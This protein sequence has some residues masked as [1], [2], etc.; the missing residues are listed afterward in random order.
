MPK[1]LSIQKKIT[2][3]FSTL[4]ILLFATAVISYSILERVEDKM[5]RV[6]V[7]DDFLNLTLE[8]RRYEKNY[9]LYKL[10]E[11]FKDNRAYLDRLDK[12]IIANTEIFS[13]YDPTEQFDK[14]EAISHTYRKSMKRLHELNLTAFND[15]QRK[16]Q[17]ILQEAIRN[18]GKK[19]TYYA[20]IFAKRE[21]G[22]IQNLLK[23]S[24]TV[25]V[26][27][28]GALVFFSV[29][30]AMILGEKIFSS[31][32][33]LEQYTRKV[34]HGEMVDPPDKD[35]EAE[36]HF[37]FQAFTRMNNELR[38]RQ[39]HMVQSEKLASLG[40]LLAGVAHEL[41]NPLSNISTSA[42]ILE[43]ELDSQ[44]KDFHH[45][46][47]DQIEEQSDKARDIVRT[48]LE[49]S[50]AKEFKKEELNLHSTI[51]SA[52]KLLRS[53]IPSEIDIEID[54]PPDLIVCADKQRIQ[55]VF[56]N[57]IKNA[58][59]ACDQ[60]GKIWISARDFMS[61]GRKEMEILVSD[62]GPGIAPE[63]LKMIFDPFFSSKDVGKGS[64]LGL[65]IVHDIIESHGG[66]ISVDSRL[67]EG[68]TFI[69]WL[70]GGINT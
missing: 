51:S 52:I 6:E 43:E 59:D 10:K 65:F 3:S 46:L 30:M 54:M 20:E 69:I 63:Y 70:P 39:R 28:T 56:L 2:F 31:L 41:N 38:L 17:E 5:Y 7:I 44:D 37:I 68:S 8:L 45:R 49:F 35:V 19:L 61:A 32:R 57:L 42:Q 60:K 14:I 23:T 66:T 67:G 1:L 9:F 16:E 34:A 33:L 40:T 58:V 29:V 4:L 22:S 55:Q 11:D 62:N 26:I 64:G 36:I 15:D 21:K 18:A 13:Y 12:T 47:V 24:R 53:E 25:L 27:S 50:R 48:L